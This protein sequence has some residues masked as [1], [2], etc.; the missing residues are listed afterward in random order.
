MTDLSNN[1]STHTRPLSP[2]PPFAQQPLKWSAKALLRAERALLTRARSGDAEAADALVCVARAR[3]DAPRALLEAVRAHDVARVRLLLRVAPP[4][5][6]RPCVSC[7]AN[8]STRRKNRT[9]N[10]KCQSGAT[11]T[12]GAA[13]VCGWRT[14]LF[15]RS[16]FLATPARTRRFAC[17]A[18]TCVRLHHASRSR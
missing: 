1:V 9:K 18:G 11:A 8:R 6:V 3:L 2:P 4:S 15:A 12:R 10:H 5:Q 17:R 14:R 7:V 16:S 13:R